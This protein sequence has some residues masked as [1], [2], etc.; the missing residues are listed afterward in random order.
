MLN[1]KRARDYASPD[2]EHLIDVFSMGQGGPAAEL[3][4]L[5]QKDLPAAR[6]GAGGVHHAALRTPNEEQYS[7]DLHALQNSG[8]I[9]VARST[10][11]FRSSLFP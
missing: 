1:M 3:H 11:Y 4:V 6:Q 10:A 8:F 5:E 9:P 7:P 2:G